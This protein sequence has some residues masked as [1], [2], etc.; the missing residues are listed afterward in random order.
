MKINPNELRIDSYQAGIGPPQFIEAVHLPT[1]TVV[2]RD[3][4]PD[5]KKNRTEAIKRLE[6]LLASKQTA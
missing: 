3:D 1:G 6:E 5:G 4:L 2:K